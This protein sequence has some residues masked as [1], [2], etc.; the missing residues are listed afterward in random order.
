VTI[1]NAV[2]DGSKEMNSATTGEWGMG[3]GLYDAS[4]VTIID[5]VITNTWGDGIYVGGASKCTGIKIYRPY[6]GGCR[7]N[8]MSVISADGLDV[9]HPTFE[10]I[11]DTNPK[12]GIDFEP[13][14]N[15]AELKNI[16]IYSPRTIYC[17]L[18]IEFYLSQLPGPKAK[19]V[20]VNIYDYV[21]IN[22]GE[23][24]NFLALAKGS[25]S[26]S[27]T[28]KVN[29]VRYIKPNFAGKTITNW[30]NS[31]ALAVTNETTVS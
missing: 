24:L 7:R 8:G 23:V 22:D 3:I 16:N 31:I 17:N 25:Y 11:N 29:G 14:D 12:A 4:N 6:I 18:G 21:S 26:V 10:R 28:I 13:N 2:I 19:V 5:P 20:S 30:D 27:G 1:E 9:Y 15:N